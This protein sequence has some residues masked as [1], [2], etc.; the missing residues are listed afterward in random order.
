MYRIC[1]RWQRVKLRILTC[2]HCIADV[3]TTQDRTRPQ[4]VLT[5]E[6]LNEIF[7]FDVHCVHHEEVVHTMVNDQV[8][9]QRPRWST[10]AVVVAV[11][12]RRDLMVLEF[13]A[14]E[15][16]HHV[17]DDGTRIRCNMPHPLIPVANANA[18]KM[19]KL[20]LAG[21]PP[22]RSGAS[23]TGQVSHSDWSYDA[24]SGLNTKGYT[25]RL[26]E[27]HGMICDSGFSGAPILN[28]LDPFQ[29]VGVYHGVHNLA[30][31]YAITSQE[32]NAFLQANGMVRAR[33]QVLI[34]VFRSL[35]QYILY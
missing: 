18:V 30:M 29:C 26:L 31:G 15:L 11:D 21:W 5:I 1:Y 32:V 17:T 3:Y 12:V 2:A 10:P 7:M 6:E 35:R 27:I 22:Q 9:S 24:V 28:G 4:D 34:H 20:V 19:Q 25:M 16:V 23:A 14:A 13:D 33:K 8:V